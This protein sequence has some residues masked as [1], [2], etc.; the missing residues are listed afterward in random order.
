MEVS[1]IKVSAINEEVKQPATIDDYHF[2]IEDDKL[3]MY[4]PLYKISNGGTYCERIPVLTKEAF[5]MCAKEWLGI[6]P[7]DYKE[8][9]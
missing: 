2:N 5:L 6:D 3:I 9:K 8:E 4:K 7:K 1:E